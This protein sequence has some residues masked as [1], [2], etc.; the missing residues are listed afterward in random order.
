VVL[1]ADT[2][3]TSGPKVWLQERKP[4]MCKNKFRSPQGN[5][6]L[7]P[8]PYQEDCQESVHEL[9]V[10]TG[11]KH[12]KSSPQESIHP[13]IHPS[14]SSCCSCCFNFSTSPS[15]LA[16]WASQKLRKWKAQSPE[17]VEWSC[18]LTCSSNTIILLYLF[19]LLFCIGV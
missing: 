15:C 2:T 8:R 14:T 11:T 4:T 9:W 13:S 10:S 5:R 3:P 1:I 17:G 18:G 16:L 6:V 7:N 12:S 19:Y